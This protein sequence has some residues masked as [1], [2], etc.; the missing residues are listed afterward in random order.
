[1]SGPALAV[2][3]FVVMNPCSGQEIEDVRA[4]RISSDH[5]EPQHLSDFFPLSEHRLPPIQSARMLIAVGT[6]TQTNT[7]DYDP[8]HIHVATVPLACLY[9][10]AS[11]I[12]GLDT[13]R[14]NPA[15]K[16]LSLLDLDGMSGAPVFSI[17]G[18]PGN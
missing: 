18:N 13:V 4:L 12:L 14:I 7:I 15:H 11:C 9:E 2:N 17:D 3:T 16:K 8:A 10:G 5:H 6:P 1:V